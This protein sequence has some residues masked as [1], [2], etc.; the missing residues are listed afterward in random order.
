MN[1]QC[2]EGKEAQWKNGQVKINKAFTA[3]NKTQT[4]DAAPKK[5]KILLVHT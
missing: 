5:K 2:I 4:L 3:I 1:V